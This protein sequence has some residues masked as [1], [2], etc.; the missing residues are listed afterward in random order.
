PKEA[1]SL[2]CNRSS[3]NS[4][5]LSPFLRCGHVRSFSCHTPIILYYDTIVKYHRQKNFALL[6]GGFPSGALFTPLSV[7]PPLRAFR[8]PLLR[9]ADFCGAPW[10]AL[11]KTGALRHSQLPVSSAGRGRCSCPRRGEPRTRPWTESKSW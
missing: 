6:R 2:G 4:M 7:S 1:R 10:Q 8:Q 3:D 9:L 5:Q 11:A